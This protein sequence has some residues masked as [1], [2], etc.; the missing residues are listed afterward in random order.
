VIEATETAKLIQ[1]E[2]ATDLTLAFKLLGA[3]A[4]ELVSKAEKDGWT[5]QHLENELMRI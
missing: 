5:I 1:S 2:M 3:D 4:M